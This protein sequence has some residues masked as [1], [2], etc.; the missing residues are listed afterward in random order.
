MTIKQLL[1]AIEC[2]ILINTLELTNPEMDCVERLGLAVRKMNND[3]T[4]FEYF[5]K[6]F[7]NEGICKVMINWLDAQN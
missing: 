1:K 6:M 5:T 4:V 2:F 7:D 3:E